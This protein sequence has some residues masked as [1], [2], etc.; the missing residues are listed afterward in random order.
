MSYFN[1]QT[2]HHIAVIGQ[3]PAGFPELGFDFIPIER[4]QL[5]LPSAAFIALIAYVESVAIAK[6]TANLRGEKI[7]PNQELIALGAA[8]LATAFS[9]GMPVAGGFSRTMV[10]F[11]AGARTQMAMLIAAGLLALAVV[12]FTPW[13]ETISQSRIGSHYFGRHLPFG[14]VKK[15]TSHLA[16]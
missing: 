13:F 2:N 8:N 5:L 6:V 16:L 1:L 12:F 15:H 3:V 14:A 9:G 4:W 7:T 10:N 11:A